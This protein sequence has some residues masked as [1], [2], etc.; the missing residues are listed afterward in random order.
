EQATVA[1]ITSES[2][3]EREENLRAMFRAAIECGELQKADAIETARPK[4]AHMTKGDLKRFMKEVESEVEREEV[5]EAVS[6]LAF[7]GVTRRVPEDPTDETELEVDVSWHGSRETCRV[8][9]EELLSAHKFETVL[10]AN[11]NGVPSLPGKEWTEMLQRL[12][13]AE[14]SVETMPCDGNVEAGVHSVLSQIA[15]ADVVSDPA[16][17]ADYPVGTLWLDTSGAET[18]LRAPMQ[19]INSAVTRAT[20][21]TSQLAVIGVLHARG[22]A[23]GPHPEVSDAIPGDVRVVSLDA[24]KL[25]DAGHLPHEMFVEAGGDA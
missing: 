12:Y 23:R 11:F 18:W 3:A 14:E 20:A 5:E 19:Y 21:H 17:V 7:H 2:D 9:P 6:G 22:W 4:M 10:K 1:F 16:A 13:P 8:S 24:L 15:F 25:V